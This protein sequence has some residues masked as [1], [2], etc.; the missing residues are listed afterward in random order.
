MVVVQGGRH[1]NK[2]AIYGNYSFIK[3]FRPLLISNN[4]YISFTLESREVNGY[5]SLSKE[6][7]GIA[8]FRT[9]WK[10]THAM[11]T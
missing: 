10:T 8:A 9:E 1:L 6:I 7:F 11:N 5:H 4:N 2:T 3:I